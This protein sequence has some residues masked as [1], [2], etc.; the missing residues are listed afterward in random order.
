MSALI[1]R[2]NLISQEIGS[3]GWYVGFILWTIILCL[4]VR[5]IGV[6][7][8]TF[9]AN[10]WGNLSFSSLIVSSRFR[11]KQINLQE[12]FIMAYGGLRG[13]VGFSL[14]KMVNR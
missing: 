8:F 10:R 1:S 11:L 4:L 6:Y 2:I 14:V 5:F 12:Q 13:G 7:I 9:I 3:D